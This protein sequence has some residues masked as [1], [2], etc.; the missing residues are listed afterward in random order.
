MTF[1]WLRSLRARSPFNSARARSRR[2]AR[3]IARPEVLE[4]RLVLSATIIDV[5]PNANANSA[6]DD[7][8]VQATF[9]QN[10][11]ASTV[12]DQT[13]VVHATQTGRLRTSTGD[14]TSLT[15][16]GPTV[17][18]NPAADFHPGELV[19]VTATSGIK[20]TSGESAQPRVWEFRAEATG[21]YAHFRDTGHIYMNYEGSNN[22]ALGDLDGDGDLDAF[23][24]G[25][26]L[27]VWLNNG[28]G[29][30][31]DNGQHLL[32]DVQSYDVALA[33]LDADG[34]LD[35]YVVNTKGDQVW[36]NSGSGIFVDSGQ[37]IGNNDGQTV[38]LGDLDGD[39]D[40]DAVVTHVDGYGTRV[41][42]NNGAGVFTDS[43][44][45]LASAA[46]PGRTGERLDLG[47]LDSDGDL[48]LVVVHH[49]KIGR[50]WM[51]DGAGNFTDS[52]QNLGTVAGQS[53]ALGDLDGDGD[54]DALVGT[55]HNNRGSEVWLNNGSG[56]LAMS[57]HPLM[58]GWSYEASL[59]DL[60]GDGDLD[61]IVGM[62]G[63]TRVWQNNGN[64]TFTQVGL[65][66]GTT[67]YGLS[68][69]DLDGDGDLDAYIVRIGHNRVWLNVPPVDL[70]ISASANRVSVVEGE[71]I[72]YTIVASN[73]GD[74]AVTGATVT[75]AIP[76]G[77]A[78]AAIASI[79]T[80][81]GATSSLT[82]GALAADLVDTVNLPVGATITYTLNVTVRQP[83]SPHAAAFATLSNSARIEAP[84]EV[85]DKNV[86][87]NLSGDSDI[88]VL[89]AIANPGGLAP[90]A[91]LLGGTASQAVA[92]GDLDGDGDVD[93]V[94]AANGGNQIW[95]NAGDGTFVRTPQTL[96]AE[97][98]QHVALGDANGDGALDLFFANTG[99]AGITHWIN[100]GAVG[101]FGFGKSDVDELAVHTDVRHLSVHD[102]DRNGSLDLLFSREASVLTG[103]NEDNGEFR[104]RFVAGGPDKT[105]SAQGDLDGDGDLDVV[106]ASDGEPTLV[107]KNKGDGTY[108]DVFTDFGIGSAL[109]VALGDLDGD[110]DLDAYL[111]RGTGTDTILLNNGAGAF[112]TS[113]PVL[114]S[115]I[116]A[117]VVLADFDGDRD[118]DVLTTG[119]DGTRLRRNNGSGNFA[120]QPRLLSE[121]A[122]RHA[123]V[124]DLDGDGD[125]DA[126]IVLVGQGVQVWKNVPVDLAITTTADRVA[127]V[128]GDTITY[129]IVASN[130]G[131]AVTGATV[132]SPF[133]DGWAD[134]RVTSIATTGGAATSLVPGELA[135]DLIDVVDLPTGSTITYT[136]EV[137]I[138]PSLSGHA[139]TERFVTST[140][141]IA[142]P[143]GVMDGDPSNNHD[144]DSDVVVLKATGG[145]AYFANSGYRFDYGH[146]T[147]ADVDGDGDL[148]V[149]VAGDSIRVWINDGNGNFVRNSVDIPDGNVERQEADLGDLDGDGD[150]DAVVRNALNLHILVNDGTGV[151]SFL[152]SVTNSNGIGISVADVDGDGDLDLITSHRN[153]AD[154]RVLLNNGQANF[155]DSGQV[156]ASGT[157]ELGD[158]DN[159]GALDVVIIGTDNV[160]RIWRNDGTGRFV[161]SGN[162]L[163]TSV[164]RL[165]LGDLDG[166]GDLDAF[167]SCDSGPRESEVWFN[168]GAGAFTKSVQVLGTSSS[169][170][171][172]LGDFD[173]DGDLDAI[174]GNATTSR[175]WT[176]NGSGVFSL[177]PLEIGV[178]NI[179]P[180]ALG[181]V[182]GDGDID[183]LLAQLDWITGSGDSNQIWLNA[184]PADLAIELSADGT[185]VTE[186][187]TV[188]YT[189]VASN[190]GNRDVPGATVTN[191]FSTG[192]ASAAI[193]SIVVTGGATSSLTTGSLTGDLVDVVTLPVGATITYTIDATIRRLPAADGA[194]FATV[195]NSARI[196][197][198]LNVVVDSNPLDNLSGDSD[199]IVLA[200]NESHAQ[201]YATGQTFGGTAIQAI[202]LGDVDGDG[203]SDAFLA[204][205]NGNQVWLNGGNGRFAKSGASFGTADSRHVALG[206]VDGDGDLDAFV[207]QMG[208]NGLRIWLNDGSGAFVDGGIGRTSSATDVTHL[209]L[210]DLNRDGELD[211]VFTRVGVSASLNRGDG[212]YYTRFTA[213][214]GGSP[215]SAVGDLDGDGDL[216]VVLVSPTRATLIWK[217]RGD[218]GFTDTFVDHGLGFASDVALGDLDGDGDLDMYLARG[219]GTDAVYRNDG[220]G[221]FTATTSVQGSNAT[222]RIALAD[223]D[224]DG[225]LDA[226]T[227]GTGGT[228]LRLNDGTG[229]FQASRL[230]NSVASG[231]AAIADLDGDGDLDVAVVDD[232]KG[233][234]VWLNDY[235]SVVIQGALATINGTD[236]DDQLA[237]DRATHTV[238]V[239]GVAHVLPPSVNRLFFDGFLGVD[240]VVVSG[241]TERIRAMI[242]PGSFSIVA[243]SYNVR[244]AGLEAISVQAVGAGNS[245]QFGDTAGDDSF[246]LS[247][248]LATLTGSGFSNRAA[249]FT[250]VT[251]SATTGNDRASLY[252]TDGNDFFDGGA[253]LSKLYGTGFSYLVAD[254][255]RVEA[256]ATR[257]GRDRARLYGTT[258][259]DNLVSSPVESTLSGTGYFQLSRGFEE[260]RAYGLAGADVARLAGSGGDDEFIGRPN[261]VALTGSGVTRT[262]EGFETVFANGGSGGNDTARLYDDAGDS[263]FIGSSIA[264]LLYSD[265][266]RL[267]ARAFDRV[268]VF[269]SGGTDRATL[270]GSGG[271][272]RLD[273]FPTRVLL[274]MPTATIELR[275]FDRVQASSTFGGTVDQVRFFDSSGDDSFYGRAKHAKLSGDG[276]ENIA[277]GFDS[278]QANSNTPGVDTLDV[279]RLDY[280][281]QQIGSWANV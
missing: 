263:T 32:G 91:Q 121:A 186:G 150:L 236:G 146:S 211:V 81:G 239:N 43:G 52:G 266:W 64:A 255:D 170:Q 278:V 2:S 80:T 29:V 163:G 216:D 197:A 252:D 267:E 210:G 107:W 124:A 200:A 257:G 89:A 53:V 132:R 251:V 253:K 185:S 99:T 140:A 66:L 229:H 179:L 45:Q 14:I 164:R 13:F 144:F 223:F 160:A 103:T 159:D 16:S 234:R 70:A 76:D 207:A 237:Y 7:T 36:L 188:T 277:D 100:W 141:S 222:K 35:A 23:V 84:P 244:G 60:D 10:I 73:I 40:V 154:T 228:Y 22:V 133:V 20:G 115:G 30:F 68:T 192:W 67:G 3:S 176:N 280:V 4:Q 153:G 102:I 62:S 44:Q 69:G 175:V 166:D 31:E 114:N 232:G 157:T 15:T 88:I 235:R 208:A 262:A 212:T 47:D 8:N 127:V 90:T 203:D 147:L 95:L 240:S 206:D 33:D 49:H 54:L 183:A 104:F 209:S 46:S 118:L 57:G 158:L 201:F 195:P 123:A 191:P 86:A 247:D 246:T 168:D 250:N 227:T 261:S 193:T 9:N 279:A 202:A 139:A 274:V 270:L 82:T 125:L 224:G 218:G 12:T 56:V 178:G 142:T 108:T 269:A 101:A 260:V 138:V 276:Y 152:R 63:E 48:D 196:D 28:D 5:D 34:D 213:G 221:K 61:A 162:T 220:T 171:N 79:V 105:R 59:A 112:T 37:R 182:D 71:T 268:N 27:D 126:T 117:T 106:L 214:T 38:G 110:G 149:F 83:G 241:D 85:V 72:T 26:Q 184:L 173:G 148:D 75:N 217:G 41:L 172:A 194:A 155:T 92:L 135:G 258:E 233:T 254:F 97:N 190:V 165:S 259:A 65:V 271:G 19:R 51:N 174:V 242:D 243:S 116:S 128:E 130:A 205:S 151:F 177:I 264:S 215:R 180:S 74:R 6:P 199:L 24:A 275:S 120:A 145:G 167:V 113:I 169:L 1:D 281:F 225:D 129:T 134:A 136:V 58:H 238:F 55:Y 42:R 161:D 39:G 245:V 78:D 77:W 156:I 249:G 272:D 25:T 111:T 87:N 137:T 265:T 17:T 204:T 143:D 189:I 122:S 96:G 18:L 248:G 50:I 11:N 94:V 230:I 219:T 109:D 131:T 93:V 98:S 256:Y 181:D 119:N 273:M 198:P 231:H 21:G 187:E 226:L